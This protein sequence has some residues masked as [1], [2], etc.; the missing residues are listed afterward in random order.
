MSIMLKKP[1]IRNIYYTKWFT[2]WD[3]YE[4]VCDSYWKKNDLYGI[5][6]KQMLDILEDKTNIAIQNMPKVNSCYSKL[7]SLLTFMCLSNTKSVSTGET[8]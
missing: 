6:H 2:G 7:L 4:T 5:N 8:K 1:L 3:V